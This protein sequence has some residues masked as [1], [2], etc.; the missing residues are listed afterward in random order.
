MSRPA[1][2][3]VAVL[4]LLGPACTSS[5]ETRLLVLAAASLTD[6]AAELETAFEADH[7]RVD[8]Q[9]ALAGTQALRL[10]I[11]QGAPADVFLSADPHHLD[12]LVTAGHVVP[13]GDFAVNEVVLIVPSA[14]PVRSMSDLVA[15]E[16]VVV[17]ADAVPIG[18]Y[19]AQVLDRAREAHGDDFRRQV[20]ARIVSREPNVRQVRAKV[21]LGEAD[22]AFVYRTDVAGLDGVRVVELPDA[23]RVQARYP[24]GRV[25]RSDHPELASAFLEH[26]TGPAGQAILARHGFGRP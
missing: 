13:H 10:Q 26:L 15:V 2:L 25:V 18:R 23:L 8:V 4:L 5:T 17:G 11:A 12:A 14:S 1:A 24:A 6:A 22:A 16:R 3:L 21:A 9:V 19:T 20:E 7:D